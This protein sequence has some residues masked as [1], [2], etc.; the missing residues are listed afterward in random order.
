MPLDSIDQILGE[1]KEMKIREGRYRVLLDDSSDPIFSFNRNGEYLY[2]NEAFA[3]GLDGV[4]K[5]DDIIGKTIWDF[6]SKEGADQRFAVVKM[7]FETGTPVNIEVMVPKDS[8]ETF[9]LTTVKPVFGKE[10]TVDYVICI[11]KNITERKNYERVLESR[12]K[13]L[14]L[15]LSQIKQLKGIVPICAYCKK[16]RNDKGYWDSVESYIST[17]TGAELSHGICPDC[18]PRAYED[19]GREPP[20]GPDRLP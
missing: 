2:V 19:L 20:Q 14:E 6:F 7:V 3:D 10:G 11:A 13:E 15:A 16:T 17:H 4:F 5:P 9:Y 12:T 1:L 8:D 18:L